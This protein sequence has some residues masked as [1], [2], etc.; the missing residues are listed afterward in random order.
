MEERC[1][2]RKATRLRGKLPFQSP[3]EAMMRKVRTLR[4]TAAIGFHSI[5]VV[6][7][8]KKGDPKRNASHLGDV[9]T[10]NFILVC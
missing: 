5:G 1:S 4:G 2:Q 3:F 7:C 10:E 6:P 9:C 8:R